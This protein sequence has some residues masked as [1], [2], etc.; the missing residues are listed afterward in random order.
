VRYFAVVDRTARSLGYSRAAVGLLLVVRTTPLTNWLPIPASHMT[1]PLL[2]WP[3]HEFRAAWGGVQLPDGAV[4]ALCVL[5]TA[6][7]VLF[8]LG[9]RTRVAGTV[10]AAA[11]FAVLS[12]DAFGFKFTL[13]TLFVGT[14]LLAISGAGRHFALRPRSRDDA[15]SS[16]WL[17][18]AFVAS[19]YLWAGIAKLRVAWLSG[20]TL[21]AL[22]ENHFLTGALADVL[23]ATLG[24]CRVAAWSVLVTELLLGPMLLVRRTRVLAL[25]LAVGM[26]AVY[27]W[28]AHPDVFGWVMIALLMSFAHNPPRDGATEP[29]RRRR[30]AE[31]RTR[32]RPRR[33]AVRRGPSHVVVGRRRRLDARLRRPWGAPPSRPTCSAGRSGGFGVSFGFRLLRPPP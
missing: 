17:V 22:Y 15:P 14:W 31:A 2:G 27:E 12:Q 4:M 13:Y 25:V 3:E 28:T 10:A 33:G 1:T 19:V 30:R 5:R 20:H 9:V 26:H 6:A 24:R 21:R 7:A 29:V 8:A 11:A 18:R 16:P 32:A 23:F